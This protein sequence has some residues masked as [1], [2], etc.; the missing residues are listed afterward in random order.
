MNTFDELVPL[1]AEDIKLLER[2]KTTVGCLIILL[3]VALMIII[4]IMLFFPNIVGV[5]AS[6]LVLLIAVGLIFVA[7]SSDNQIKLDLSEGKKRVIIAP[8]EKK[9]SQMIERKKHP[10]STFSDYEYSYKYWI[11]VKGQT[12]YISEEQFLTSFRK[13]SFIEAHIA[14]H[15][16]TILLEPVEKSE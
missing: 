2:K 12:F 8:I 15:S 16:K 6:V 3:A 13:G 9:D 7:R 5:I 11:K 14:P 4:A 1:S 10:R